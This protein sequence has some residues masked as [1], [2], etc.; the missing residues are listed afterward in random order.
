MHLGTWST[1]SAGS[2]ERFDYW[3]DIVCDTLLHVDAHAA[4][5]VSRFSAE[6]SLKSHLAG[7]FVRFK[8]QGHTIERSHR[9]LHAKPD[10]RYLVSYQVSGVASVTQGDHRFQLRPGDV[11]IVSAARPMSLQFSDPVERIIA[12]VPRSA[13]EKS[14]PWLSPGVALHLPGEKIATRILSH[15]LMELSTTETEIGTNEELALGHIIS[16]LVGVRPSQDPGSVRDQ[17]LRSR[18]FG[19]LTAHIED[20][21]L[22]PGMVANQIGISERSLHYVLARAGTTFRTFIITER[23]DRAAEALGS[24]AWSHNSVSDIAFRL[25]FQDLSHFSRRFKERFGVPP[26]SYRLSKTG[27]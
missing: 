21:E 16:E 5:D 23:L 2:A 10:E 6:L 17:Q 11:G 18:V 25:G 20:P 27:R 8:S 13:L 7:N 22:A 14:C 1:M 3:K 24:P 4:A 9:L 26:S 15:L 19:F 12:L